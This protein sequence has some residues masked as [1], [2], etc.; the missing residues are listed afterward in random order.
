MNDHDPRELIQRGLVEAIHMAAFVGSEPG[1]QLFLD[2]VADWLGGPL[3]VRMHATVRLQIVEVVRMCLQQPGGVAALV[4]VVDELEPMSQVAARLRELREEWDGLGAVPGLT[5]PTRPT[6]LTV[7]NRDLTPLPASPVVWGDVPPRNAHFTGREGL[8][9]LLHERLD[10]GTTAL[11]PQTL[12]GMG[13]VGKSQLATEYLHRHA[14]D[15][16]IVWWIAAER[17]AQVVS[18]LVELA[19]RLNLPAAAE[20][21]TAVPAVL[22]S[23]RMG[24]PYAKW[25]LVFDNADS[26]EAVLPY[27][28]AGNSGCILV[29]SRNARW[30]TVVRALEV[31]VFSRSESKELLRRHGP[32]LTDGEADRLAT[33][34][35]DLPLAVEQAAAWR[36]ETGMPAAE[37]L[38]LFEQKRSDLLEMSAPLDYRL[39]VAAAWNVSLDRL[40]VK[41]SAAT[42]LLQVCAF[43]APEPISR[44]LFA[45]AGSAEISATLDGPLHDPVRLGEAIREIGRY[46][47]ARIDH[48]TNSIQI[49]R[50]V[51][52]V[53]VRRMTEEQRE[54][55]RHAAHLLLAANN[56]GS[57]ELTRNWRRYGELYPH[58]VASSAVDCDDESVRDLV[59]NEAIYLYRWGERE[60]A[61]ELAERAFD[62][63]RDSLGIEHP[64]T[65]AAAH[66][67]SFILLNVGRYRAAADLNTRL[68][69]A[70]RQTVGDDHVYTLNALAR[71]AADR[72]R[73]GDFAAA[74]ELSTQVY[75]GHVRIHGMSDP[76]STNAAHNL[77]VSL[78]LVGAFGRALALDQD[79]WMRRRRMFGDDHMATLY[80]ASS[81][82]VDRRELGD[83]LGARELHEQL[84]AQYRHLCGDD[85]PST[86][87]EMRH[88]SVG[89][90]KAGDYAGARLL[91][92]KTRG[93]SAAR[94]GHDHVTTMALSLELSIDLRLAGEL[95]AAR[96]LGGETVERYSRILGPRHPH[97]LSARVN[98]AITHRLLGDL[99]T[100][101]TT[102]SDVLSRLQ[103]GLDGEH[104]LKLACTINL[105][106]DLY[107]E[108][109][110]HRAYGTDAAAW[111]QS[112][113]VFGVDHPNTLACAMNLAMDLR[114]LGQGEA[115]ATLHHDTT[116]RFARVLGAN[117]PATVDA[118]DLAHRAN[119]DIDPMPL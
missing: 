114:A 1:R 42:Q 65:E 60:A 109:E 46:S 62:A 71:V 97:T 108:G 27:F 66:W 106:S 85:N 31:D 100:A 34:L 49:H 82:A 91:A 36:A 95:T 18:A 105:A 93:R 70:Y 104:P 63:W 72:R 83:Y 33:A 81:V 59:L 87:D 40:E 94:H 48:R 80:S 9:G 86:L 103:A 50:L 107:A 6:R 51:Q 45:V 11:L 55:M 84:A 28:P 26:P 116:A 23:L 41:S 113:R 8:L 47:L 98:L 61:R 58:V 37:Y 22:D 35:G 67:L 25:I 77:G 16:D 79:T 24:I 54:I 64:Q 119:I 32:E 78:R 115:A 15:Y 101:R 102:N 12:Y 75:L 2:R 117:H 112:K 73:S 43:F 14:A 56:P 39:P 4:G 30:G 92:T 74:L 89:R 19:Q 96:E 68:M 5:A 3:P 7:A 10:A 118:V 53:L 13:G 88:L 44:T 69:E 20:A 52:A 99:E 111:E 38:R 110:V 21:S 90:R 17:P 57:P 76:D 29:T